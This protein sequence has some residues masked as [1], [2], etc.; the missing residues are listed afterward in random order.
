MNAGTR[1]SALGTRRAAVRRALARAARVARAVIGVPDYERYLEHRR[2]RHPDEPLLS[3]E[4]FARE[5]ERA[6][7]ERPGA[8]CC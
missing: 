2:S 7:Y 4:Q 5:G 3:Q 6:R 1:R 8:R